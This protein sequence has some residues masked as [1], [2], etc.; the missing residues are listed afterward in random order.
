[1]PTSNTHSPRKITPISPSPSPSFL[2]LPPHLRHTIY[3]HLLVSPL[4]LRGPTARQYLEESTDIHTAIL[5][6]SKQIHAEARCV[7][8]GMN[9]FAVNAVGG[10]C[11]IGNGNRAE[12]GEEEGSGAF[13]PPLQ[14]KDVPLI[15]N[16]NID[17]LYWPRNTEA[18]DY[19]GAQRYA[20]NLSHLLT[21]LKSSLQSLT[22]TADA[23][24]FTT[25]ES[26]LD[27]RRFL[28]SFHAASTNPHFQSALSSLPLKKVGVRFEF[29]EM[30]FDFTVQ[31]EV[32]VGGGLVWLA[33]Q[34]LV[35]RVE[36]GLGVCADEIEEVEMMEE[37]V[38]MNVEGMEAVSREVEIGEEREKWW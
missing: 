35:K 28:S 20:T 16:L 13:E 8:F 22:L 18:K 27:H 21:Q 6:V 11:G 2:A 5:R 3:T 36:I 38:E 17:L 1:M 25:P 23:R 26:S 14:L 10:G 34:V 33:G 9:T 29:E 7:F 15:R 32:L 24:P 31:K 12:E 37:E 30:W 4:P 19:N